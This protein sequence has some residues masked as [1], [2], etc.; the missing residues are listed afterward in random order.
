MAGG[1][2]KVSHL[3]PR[4]A[5]GIRPVAGAPVAGAPGSAPRFR[6]FTLVELLTVV[7]IMVILLAIVAPAASRMWGQRNEANAANTLR[8]LLASARTQA[9]RT[10]ERG[11]FFFVD[12]NDHV[13]RVVFL[14]ADPPNYTEAGQD[15][16]D[17]TG[18]VACCDHSAATDCDLTATEQC[19]T[20]VEAINRFRVVPGSLYTI[21][22][23]YRMAPSWVLDATW[24]GHG[25]WPTQLVNAKY[26]DAETDTPRYQRNFFTILFNNRGEMIVGRNILIHDPDVRENNG[27]GDG[28]G[29]L[30]GLAIG[31]VDEAW[32]ALQSSGAYSSA[33]ISTESGA[34]LFDIVTLASGRA[35]NFVSAAGVVIYDDSDVQD[36]SGDDIRAYLLQQAEP[37]YVTRITGDIIAGPKGNR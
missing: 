12:Q 11:L 35:A 7:A 36:L 27:N 19:V 4:V 17:C 10:G 25:T 6:G 14:E 2:N 32:T 15:A 33:A 3:P 5:S 20:Q 31:P 8:G 23:P 18:R 34:D 1:K 29:D 26:R 24:S 37:F 16:C 21:P 22:A 30:T 9:I 28:F 13:Q